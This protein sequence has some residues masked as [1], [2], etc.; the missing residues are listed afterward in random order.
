V[1]A[2]ARMSKPKIPVELQVILQELCVADADE[3]AL[4]RKVH[5]RAALQVKD[6]LSIIVSKLELNKRGRS[7]LTDTI[8]GTRR[9]LEHVQQE[10]QDAEEQREAG[11][12]VRGGA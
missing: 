10:E 2:A 11:V 8:D 6:Y 7:A 4:L 5:T 1:S 3:A 12:V 9:M